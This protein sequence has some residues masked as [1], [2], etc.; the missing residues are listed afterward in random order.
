[1]TTLP[2]NRGFTFPTK[3]EVREM[4]RDRAVLITAIVAAT[5][6]GSVLLA[7]VGWLIHDDKPVTELLALVS[8]LVSGANYVKTSRIEKQTNGTAAR[9]MDHALGPQPGRD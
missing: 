9:L 8:L 1:M 4:L 5:I 6:M 3:A 7:T 2:L